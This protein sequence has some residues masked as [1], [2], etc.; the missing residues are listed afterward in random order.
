MESSVFI[1]STTGSWKPKHAQKAVA[2]M[3][4]GGVDSSVTARLLLEKGMEVFGVTMKIPIA[5]SCNGVAACCGGEAALIADKL[6]IPHFFVDVKKVFNDQ[7]IEPFRRDYACGRTPSPCIDCNTFIKF[8]YMWDRIEETFGVKHVATGHYAKIIEQNGRTRLARGDDRRRDQS[9]FLYGI[10]AGRLPYFHL[11][12]GN[13]T[14]KEVRELAAQAELQVAGKPD[15]MELCFAGEGDYRAALGE[16]GGDRPGDIV[17][18]DGHILG[19]HEGIRNY[20][21]GQRKGIGIPASHPLYVIKVDPASNRIVVGKREEAFTQH[22]SI[23]DLNL[24]E[25]SNITVGSQLLGKIRSSGEPHPLTI[26][27]LRKDTVT[28]SFE[29]PVFAAAPGQHLVF[30]TSD[31]KVIGGGKIT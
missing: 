4:S 30:Y 28:V 19:R 2:V 23:T 11:P 29:Q 21:A 9:Y 15:S 10:P 14:K 25:P 3:M 18:S 26:T 5:Q 27:D 22:I 16:R 24:L 20:T 6:G 17:D 7:V 13:F 12:M 31:D 1:H 8:G